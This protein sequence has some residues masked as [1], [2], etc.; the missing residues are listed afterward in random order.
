MILHF[1]MHSKSSHG[2]PCLPQSH[3]HTQAA[4]REVLHAARF[5]FTHQAALFASLLRATPT[6]CSICFAFRWTP[7]RFL[8]PAFLAA[9]GA[10][11]P[12]P[13]RND[14]TR[15]GE[16]RRTGLGSKIRNKTPWFLHNPKRLS[17]NHL[18]L[19]SSSWAKA[20]CLLILSEGNDLI[21][22]EGEGISKY[23]DVCTSMSGWRLIYVHDRA[24]TKPSLLDG[25]Q[26]F[27]AP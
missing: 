10:F 14:F 16:P 13:P 8:L 6:P 5:T 11:P 17:A 19:L 9:T 26:S 2:L 15:S 3:S 27:R 1:N 12:C 25:V 21:L 20:K 18:A 22:W 24:L 7:H 4:Q 23:N